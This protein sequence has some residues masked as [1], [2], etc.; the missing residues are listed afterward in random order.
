MQSELTH[1]LNRL[2]E[3]RLE[4]LEA[5]LALFAERNFA[6]VTIK[7]I[8]H[9]L[10]LNAGLIYYYFKNKKD[11]LR[12]SLSHVADATFA[13]FRDLEKQ[14]SR[15]M[16]VINA[17]L[18]RNIEKSSDMYRFVKIALDFRGAKEQDA[19][20]EAII[21]QFYQSER[22][23]LVRVIRKGMEEGAFADVNPLHVSNF[24][25]TH[26]DGCVIRSVVMDDFS[27]E[28]EIRYLSKV[29]MLMLGYK[30]ELAPRSARKTKRKTTQA[31][32]T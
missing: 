22:K 30:K 29:V 32:P 16:D 4:F 20:V 28:D 23:M 1:S 21:Q 3:R 13:S 9:R 18:E 5:A 31:R 14:S 6:S 12:A 2:A 10:D 15:P 19:G 8:A 24:I 26:L 27:V 25:S 7:D 17:W 11:L